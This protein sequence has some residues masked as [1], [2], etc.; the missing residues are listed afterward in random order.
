MNNGKGILDLET[1]CQVLVKFVQDET[2][3]V[4]EAVH[5]RGFTL[6]IPCT[7]V[8]SKSLLEHFE[9][10]HPVNRKIVRLHISFVE[11]Q[12]KRQLCFVKN[13]IN[14][15]SLSTSQSMLDGTNLQA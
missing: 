13:A 2:H 14:R 8:G 5:V 12:D 9:I 4:H 15:C 10:F 3:A 7:T 6:G 1:D 11:N